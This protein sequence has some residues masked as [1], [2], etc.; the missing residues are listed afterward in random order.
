MSVEH[1][2][3]DT[4]GPGFGKI[5]LLSDLTGASSGLAVAQLTAEDMREESTDP[6]RRSWGGGTPETGDTVVSRLSGAGRQWG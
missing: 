2:L 3:T 6:G 1:K 5:K 4:R